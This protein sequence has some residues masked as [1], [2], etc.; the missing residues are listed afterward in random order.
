MR[1]LLSIITIVFVARA[2]CPTPSVNYAW[3]NGTGVQYAFPANNPPACWHG[4]SITGL[5]IDSDIHAAF[6]RWS[7]ADQNQNSSEVTFYFQPDGN[8][9]VFAQTVVN[10]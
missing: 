2:D 9:R 1:K 3:S 7:W 4:E 5:G 8:F 6:T 10:Y